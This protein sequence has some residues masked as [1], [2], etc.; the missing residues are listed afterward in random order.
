MSEQQQ[1][2]P[3]G[4]AAAAGKRT[5]RSPLDEELASKGG[6]AAHDTPQRFA[7]AADVPDAPSGAP[8]EVQELTEEAQLAQERPYEPHSST[9]APH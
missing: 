4:P 8:R 3:T 5:T 6:E 2:P 9:A 7:P 1:T